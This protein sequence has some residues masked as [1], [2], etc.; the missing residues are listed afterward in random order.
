MTSLDESKTIAASSATLPPE[1]ERTVLERAVVSFGRYW[2]FLFLAGLILYFSLGTP[3]HAFFQ[4][5]NFKT[6]ALDT[7]EVILLAI[8]E[9]FV[10]VTA[11]ID[12]SVGGILLF[13]GVA[14]GTVMLDLSGTQAQVESLQYPHASVAVPVGVLVIVATSIVLGFLNGVLVTALR[15][16]SFIVTLG[17]LGMFFGAADL[18]SGGT[19]ISAVPSS[20][21]DTIGNGK[22]LGLFVPVVIAIGFVAATHVLLRYTRFGR[23]TAAIGSNEEASR[24]AGIAVDAHLI[25][26]YTLAGFLA[27]VA[28]IIDLSRFGSMNL[29]AHNT[30]NLNA[31]AAVVI[32][33]TSLFGGIGTILGTV[34]GAFIPT[35]L[36]N[37]FII[38]GVDP[39]WQEL[40]VGATIIVAVYLDQLRRRRLS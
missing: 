24:R 30:D 5:N 17:T 32:G 23:Y 14:G 8:G 34:V 9:T 2:L 21:Q 18:L 28:A 33:G 37:G 16:P 6:I 26:V 12:L 7:S 13:S 27:G 19:N 29:A 15:L 36:Q 10:I 39:F 4:T 1:D 38:Q 3:N 11:G 31:I 22:V 35:V 40:L 20:F 25:K